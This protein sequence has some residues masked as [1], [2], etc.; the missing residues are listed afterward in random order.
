MP[1]KNDTDQ[2]LPNLTTI[3]AQTATEK[4][5]SLHLISDSIAQQRQTASRAIL[6]HPLTLTLLSLIL[7]LLSQ[8]LY[9]TPS[10]WILLLTTATDCIATLLLFTRYITR[11]YLDQ[12]ER[13]GTC[14]WLYSNR[15]HNSNSLQNQ[16][17][18]SNDPRTIDRD[19]DLILITKFGDRIIGTLVLRVVDTVSEL[20]EHVCVPEERLRIG[21]VGNRIKVGVIRAWTVQLEYRGAGAGRRLLEAAVQVCRERGWRG[22]MFSEGHANSR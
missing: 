18:T 4:T 2:P 10:D 12:A 19:R 3:L 7:A 15:R 11:G 22:P 8:H 17:S 1:P 5:T 9:K 14:R 13:V 21:V 6:L 16:N 20:E